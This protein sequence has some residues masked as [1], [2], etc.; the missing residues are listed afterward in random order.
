MGTIEENVKEILSELETGNG[1]GEEI[2]LVAA[3]KTRTPDEV[4]R[5]IAAGVKMVG[6]NK[7][8]EFREKFDASAG[9]ERHFIGNLQTN[10]AKYLVGRCE[11]IHSVGSLH[12]A[13]E[14]S[15][16][17]AQRNTVQNILIEINLGEASKGGV[18]LEEADGAYRTIS[19]L[20]GIEVKGFMAMLPEHGELPLLSDLCKR[21]RQLFVN[22]RER[23]EKIVYLS[24]G[25][26]GDWRL[27]AE[28]GSNMIRLGSSLFGP[29]PAVRKPA[30]VTE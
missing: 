3:T 19:A 9:A 30:P 16:L 15:R 1:F 13:E 7:V 10:K 17:A 18:P 5:A 12:L 4:A 6:E 11:L 25:M 28:H 22:Y 20:G 2:S 27:C 24:M 21:M 29:R 8:Q 26:S 23:D 14:I